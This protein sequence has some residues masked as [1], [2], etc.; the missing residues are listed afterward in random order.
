MKTG[1]S[2]VEDQ[3][4]LVLNQTGDPALQ[5][6]VA[7]WTDATTASE[8]ARRSDIKRDKAKAAL[9][10][11]AFA[12]KPLEA[13]T[14][15]DVKGWQIEMEGKGLAAATVYARICH[16]SS[17]FRWVMKDPLLGR[18]V[19]SN[20]VGYA[21]PKAPKPYQTRSAKALGKKQAAALLS[22]VQARADSGDLT[23]KR[24]YALLLFY[25]ATG[26]RRSEVISLRSGDLR[27]EADKLIIRGRVKGGDYEGRAVASRRVRAAL[28][29]YLRSSRRLHILREDQP[30]WTRHDRAGEPGAPLSSWSFV[31]NLKRYAKEAG[32][33]KIHLHQTRHTFARM[34]AERT[35]SLS[36]TQDALGHRHAATTR[37]YVESIAEK[38]DKYSRYILEALEL[39]EIDEI[40]P[41]SDLLRDDADEDP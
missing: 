40:E 22:V 41:F 23:G 36:E 14:A 38:K 18:L 13:V 1:K 37:V 17:F 19:Q 20:P 34:V 9:S 3:K 25:I 10:F 28:L 35:G 5:T 12:G 16:L 29:D 15:T 39:P 26:M 11:F 2:R 30:L 27:F 7:L 24:D 33:G 6:A 31:E 4:A 32:I 21:H 8:S